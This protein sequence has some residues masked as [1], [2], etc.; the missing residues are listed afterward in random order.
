MIVLLSIL[1]IHTH[2]NLQ[3]GLKNSIQRLSLNVEPKLGPDI[4]ISLITDEKLSGKIYTNE[5][6][7][8]YLLWFARPDAKVS[9]DTRNNM[10]FHDYQLQQN[11]EKNIRFNSEV[12]TRDLDQL[13][14]DI[15]ILPVDSFPFS[16][17][18]K[19]WI[20]IAY[21]PNVEIF[22]RT[23]DIQDAD[24]IRKMLNLE[25]TASSAEI[26]KASTEFFGE[27][28]YRSQSNQIAELVKNPSEPNVHELAMIEWNS[29]HDEQAIS[30]L[31]NHLHENPHCIWSATKIAWIL[32]DEGKISESKQMLAPFMNATNTPLSTQVLWKH[33][34]THSLDR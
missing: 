21:D 2:L 27:K 12:V 16:H 8:S 30:I 19:D 28:Y 17:W 1:A 31:S 34:Q 33:L 14:M 25:L 10:S 29:N 13:G 7:G 24:R 20:R 5:K 15:A 4:A 23:T 32:H 18:P 9:G 22:L 6:W 3:G 26:Q 11:I